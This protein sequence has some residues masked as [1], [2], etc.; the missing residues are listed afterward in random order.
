MYVT[1]SGKGKSRVIQYRED[2]RIP[3][4]KKKKA[5]VIET[6]G[7][8]EKMSA[9]NPNILEELRAEAKKISK[10]KKAA[11]APLTIEVPTDDIIE[12]EDTTPSYL[13]GHALLLLLWKKMKLDA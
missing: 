8:F 6:I 13:F 3:G 2:T 4:T 1:V 12:E 11:K 9:E 5:H 10:A 7:N